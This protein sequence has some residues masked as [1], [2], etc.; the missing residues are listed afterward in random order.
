MAAL[1]ANRSSSRKEGRELP[2]LVAAGV[3][4]FENALVSLSGG[5]AIPAA[6]TASTKFVGTAKNECDNTNGADGDLTVTV[7]VQGVEQVDG[8]FAATDVGKTGLIVDDHTVQTAATTN[9]IKAG[10]IVEVV[11]SATAMLDYNAIQAI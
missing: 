10:L 8:S 11:D 6:D 7:R 5:Y 4:I 9:N 3:H 2:F 1:A